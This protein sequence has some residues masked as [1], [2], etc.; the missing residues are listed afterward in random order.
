MRRTSDEDGTS[1][2]GVNERPETRKIGGRELSGVKD[3]EIGESHGPEQ[4][5]VG[6][7]VGSEGVFVGGGE[8]GRDGV[9]HGGV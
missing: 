1:N 2:K 4:G 8:D 9:R 5:A 7:E 3:T 6:G